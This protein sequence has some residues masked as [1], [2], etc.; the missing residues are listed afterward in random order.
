M[1]FPLWCFCGSRP[2]FVPLRQVCWSRVRVTECALSISAST[3]GSTPQHVLQVGAYRRPFR[4]DDRE[5]H[6]VAQHAI[7]ADLMIAQDAVLLRTEPLDGGA[8]LL[9][10]EMRAELDSDC[11]QRFE[12]M[13]EQEQLGFGIERRALHALCVPRMTDLEPAMRRLD[14]EHAR[15]ADA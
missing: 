9:V 5:H 2:A 12:G 14:I 15:R 11:A 10:H 1:L 7:L 3:G 8:R 13:C 4:F 6:G